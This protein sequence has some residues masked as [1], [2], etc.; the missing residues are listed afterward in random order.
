MS[1]DLMESIALTF[2]GFIEFL[3]ESEPLEEAQAVE[4]EPTNRGKEIFEIQPIL[5]GGSPND[6]KNKALFTREQHIEAVNFWN[7]FIKEQQK[8]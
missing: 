2:N 1:P 4:L 7:K 8:K 5:L 6:L 3:A